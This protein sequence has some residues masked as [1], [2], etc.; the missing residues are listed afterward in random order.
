MHL[1]IFYQNKVKETWYIAKLR[2]NFKYVESNVDDE[3]TN[4]NSF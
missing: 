4:K 1:D 2:Q 3:A